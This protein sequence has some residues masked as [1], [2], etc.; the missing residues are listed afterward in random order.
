MQNGIR[1]IIEGPQ[2]VGKTKLAELI[3]MQLKGG[4][5]FPI[6]KADHKDCN[7]IPVEI[8]ERQVQRGGG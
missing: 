4:K 5:S 8:I 7:L 2:G 1:I 6:R 3:R